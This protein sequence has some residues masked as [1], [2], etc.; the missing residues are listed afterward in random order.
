[1]SWHIILND[2]EVLLDGGT[3]QGAV[4]FQVW[5]NMQIRHAEASKLEPVQLLSTD[6]HNDL[7]FWGYDSSLSNTFADHIEETLTI[8]HKTTALLLG[9]ANDAYN[10]EPVDLILASLWITFLEVFKDRNG[11]TIFIEGHGREPWSSDIDIS[12]TVGWF[13]TMTPLHISR[14]RNNNNVVRAI[15]DSRRMLRSNGRE[16]FVSRYHNE[17]GKR[18]FQSHEDTMEVLF[19]YHGHSKLQGDDTTFMNASFDN[20]SDGLTELSFSWNEC[21]N[22]QFSIRQWFQEIPGSA[23]LL[24]SSLLALQPSLTIADYEFLHLDYKALD[25]LQDQ[26]LPIIQSNTGFSVVDVFPCWPMVDGIL[27]SQGK[28]FSAYKTSSTYEVM[29]RNQLPNIDLLKEAWQAVVARHPA[30]RSV[31]V[32]GIDKRTAFVQI[33]LEYFKGEVIVTTAPTR[34]AALISIDQL[35]NINYQSQLV[36]P[37]RL[38]LYKIEQDSTIICHIEM[39]HAITDAYTGNDQVCFG[40]TASGR[41]SH[42][43]DIDRSVGAYANLLICQADTSSHA[44][45]DTRRF[46][47]YMHAQVMRDLEYQHCPL[48]DIE[49]ELGLS[50]SQSLFNTIVSFQVGDVDS[51]A[52]IDTHE[53]LFHDIAYKDPTEFDISLGIAYG[54]TQV[55]LS[56]DSHSSYL[57]TT[58]AERT[59]SLLKSVLMSLVD[60]KI[61]AGTSLL[62]TVAAIS[63]QDLEEIWTWN[64]AAPDPTVRMVPNS[65]AVCAWDGDWTYQELGSLSPQLAHRLISMGVGPEKIVGLCFEKCRWTPIAALAVM[66]AGGVSLIVDLDLT[67]NRPRVIL[68]QAQPT[69]VLTSTAYKETAIA[70]ANDVDCPMLVVDEL[71]QLHSE[72]PISANFSTDVK[73]NNTLYIVFTSDSTGVPKGVSIRHSNFS[74]SIHYLRKA[75]IGKEGFPFATSGIPPSGIPPYYS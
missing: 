17:D 63:A 55:E 8:D 36:P 45:T 38:V 29:Q 64:H 22:H 13:T 67:D 43:P 10:T 50:H 71:D 15:K 4:P 30:L 58:Q 42:I 6:N 66:K 32:D 12:R 35:P 72:I 59:L 28:N 53:L 54:K 18:Y 37:H 31:F 48:A 69:V 20:V 47:Q 39:G 16:Y 26:I 34:H 41:D 24:C 52:D 61:E 68:E 33:V 62:S 3:L 49:H 57:S 74:S 19:N 73:P 46:V 75:V 40:Y 23:R 27:L 44:L 70:M 60:L 2:L 51:R 14:C 9:K 56:L 7:Q 65:P 25:Q 11:L 5:N 21:I 1:M